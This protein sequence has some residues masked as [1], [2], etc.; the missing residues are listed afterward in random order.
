MKKLL[1][2]C[3]FL[4]GFSCKVFAESPDR[5]FN[6]P[7][8]WNREAIGFSS[9]TAAATT[10]VTVTTQPATDLLRISV[11]NPGVSSF[12]EVYDGRVSTSAAGVKFLGRFDTTGKYQWYEGI[13]ISSGIMVHNAGTTPAGVQIQYREHDFR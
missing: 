7:G 3:A 11:T 2:M 13:G 8:T 5:K 1:F 10:F 12:I 6:R 4:V 9:Y